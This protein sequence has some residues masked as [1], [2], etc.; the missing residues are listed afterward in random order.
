MRTRYCYLGHF[1][2]SFEIYCCKCNPTKNHTWQQ[3]FCSFDQL[4]I[5]MT[6]NRMPCYR[7]RVNCNLSWSTYSLPNRDYLHI[8][9]LKKKILWL[10]SKTFWNILA[11]FKLLPYKRLTSSDSI[12]GYRKEFHNL[13]YPAYLMSPPMYLKSASWFVTFLFCC[14]KNFM[15]FLPHGNL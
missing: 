6:V 8:L 10:S 7:S 3:S 4:M 2:T 11:D 1:S 12:W 13:L 5:S 14:H 9:Y 15:K